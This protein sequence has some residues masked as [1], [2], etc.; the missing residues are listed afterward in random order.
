MQNGD[1]FLSASS[2]GRSLRVQIGDLDLIVSLQLGVLLVTIVHGILTGEQVLLLMRSA[3]PLL[4][5]RYYSR[6][7]MNCK[8]KIGSAH[9]IIKFTTTGTFAAEMTYIL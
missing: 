2:R 4:F 6:D 1:N 8:W 7:V 5:C 9:R 3:C